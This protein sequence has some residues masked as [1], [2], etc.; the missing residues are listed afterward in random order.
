M[1]ASRIATSREVGKQQKKKKCIGSGLVNGIINR[2]PFELHVPGYQFCGPGTRLPKRLA[3][4][5]EGVNPL[6][7]ACRNH[8]IA[9]SRRKDLEGRHEADRALAERARERIF[10]NDATF[11]EKAAATGVWATMKVKTKLGMCMR[12]KKRKQ[13]K[14]G[15]KHP[16]L[17]RRHRNLRVAKRVGFLQFLLFVLSALSAIGA[18]AGG[19]AGITKVVNDSKASRK[20]LEQT[21]RHNRAMEGRG[22]HLTP[23]K[24]GAGLNPRRRSQRRLRSKK[25]KNVDRVG[26]WRRWWR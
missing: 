17:R 14:S 9:Y 22:M 6:N 10:A 1:V 19:A 13:R 12:R 24:R 3:R 11:G 23:Y 7:A 26:A 5:D 8:D 16:Q 18:L 15:R 25:K 21:L 2:L 20:Q 4:A